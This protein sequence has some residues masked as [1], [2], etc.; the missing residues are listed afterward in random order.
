MTTPPAVWLPLK[1][2]HPRDIA[3]G[4]LRR[5][6]AEA[7]RPDLLRELAMTARA[8]F[9]FFPSHYPYTLNYPWVL[10]RLESLPGRSRVLDVG[11]G[12][13]P[14]PVALARRN[15]QV[16]CVDNSE[17]VR[18]VPV[19]VDWNEWGFF[20]YSTI[21][22]RI[23]SLHCDARA[24]SPAQPYDALYSV[25]VLAHM[26]RLERE[27]VVARLP[28]WLSPRGRALIVID[29]VPQTNF[30]WNRSDGVEV[31]PGREH[32]TVTDLFNWICQAG[33][34]ITEWTVRRAV[35]ASRTDLLF[36]EA[37]RPT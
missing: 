34:T 32:G 36:L 20:D 3:A 25:A 12:V 10:E 16:D 35:H 1:E 27:E 15:I 4:E 7:T 18:R 33:L 29:L 13:T 11:A 21:D 8:V 5:A 26:E 14:L 19:E 23:R 28:T 30:L 24:Y 37:L 22:T 6:L 17:I 9:G 2:Q 31:A